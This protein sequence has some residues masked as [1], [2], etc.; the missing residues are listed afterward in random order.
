MDAGL[1]ALLARKFPA[2]QQEPHAITVVSNEQV[3]LKLKKKETK[4]K[5]LASHLQQYAGLMAAVN[6]FITDLLLPQIDADDPASFVDAQGDS[7]Y[8]K[9][10]QAKI[11]DDMGTLIFYHGASDHD[12]LEALIWRFLFRYVLADSQTVLEELFET[13]WESRRPAPGGMNNPPARSDKETYENGGRFVGQIDKTLLGMAFSSRD[14]AGTLFFFFL[15]FF[16]VRN[17]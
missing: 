16:L 14:D 8:A 9:V 2:E 10:L 11:L 4:T 17:G 6:D 5:T 12:V 1:A 13:R 3:Q 15:P 7:N